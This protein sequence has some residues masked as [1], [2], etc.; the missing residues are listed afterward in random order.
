MPKTTGD[1]FVKIKPSFDTIKFSK[2]EKEN[3]N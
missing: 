3:V 1:V 2:G